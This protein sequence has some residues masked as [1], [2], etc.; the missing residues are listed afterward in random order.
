[1]TAWPSLFHFLSRT[2]DLSIYPCPKNHIVAM[3][4]VDWLSLAV[5]VAYLGILLGSLATF[6]SLYRKRKSRMWNT[7]RKPQPLSLSD[8]LVR[9]RVQLSPRLI[10]DLWIIYRQGS[11]SRAMVPCPPPAWYLLLSPPP[12]TL[13]NFH[14]REEGPRYPWLYLQGFSSPSRSWRHP[15]HYGTAHPEASSH[16]A[17]PTW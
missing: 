16:N 1:M 17:R 2:S 4:D 10:Y 13:N 12:W 5:P 9:R 15:S 11:I 6:S 8:H 7:P 14:K 3:F